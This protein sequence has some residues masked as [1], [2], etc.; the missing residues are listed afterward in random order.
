[1]RR[2]VRAR[3]CLQGRERSVL[4]LQRAKRTLRVCVRVHAHARECGGT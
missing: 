1:M 3:V 2:C 4:V